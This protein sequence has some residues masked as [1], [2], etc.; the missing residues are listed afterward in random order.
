MEWFDWWKKLKC[1]VHVIQNLT[2]SSDMFNGLDSG[3]EIV[4]T[5]RQTFSR[6]HVALSAS[7]HSYFQWYFVTCVDADSCPLQMPQLYKNYKRKN[8]EGLSFVFLAMW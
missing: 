7:W 4:S 2:S 3:S 8:V 6:S 5:L 1:I